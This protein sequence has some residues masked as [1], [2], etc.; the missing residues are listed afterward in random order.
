VPGPGDDIG[1]LQLST[2]TAQPCRPQRRYGQDSVWGGPRGGA[3][4][5]GDMLALNSADRNAISIQLRIIKGAPG[6]SAVGQWNSPTH[7]PADDAL[8][9]DTAAWLC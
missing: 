1:L 7:F 3:Y 6:S 9:H 4:D 8:I 5:T 2:A